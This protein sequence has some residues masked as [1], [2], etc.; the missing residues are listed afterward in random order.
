[1]NLN[2]VMEMCNTMDEMFKDKPREVLLMCL[3]MTVDY[4]AARHGAKPAELLRQLSEVSAV[5]N[6]EVG[7]VILE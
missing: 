2:E 6:E 4:W 7:E 3:G 5:V 1:M